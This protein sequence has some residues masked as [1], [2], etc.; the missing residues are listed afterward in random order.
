MS[1]AIEE[2][3]QLL[4]RLPASATWNDIAYEMYVRAKLEIGLR[5]ADEGEVIDH[6]EIRKEFLG[7]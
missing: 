3:R 6:E 4:D 5:E 7:E 2:A 1:L